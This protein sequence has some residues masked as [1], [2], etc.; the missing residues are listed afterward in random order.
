[1][2][3]HEL[4]KTLVKVDP[5]LPYLTNVLLGGK[6]A[7]KHCACREK[8]Q[9]ENNI[10]AFLDSKLKHCQSIVDVTTNALMLNPVIQ[11]AINTGD[12]KLNGN[13]ATVQKSHRQVETDNVTTD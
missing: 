13:L 7:Q 9:K 4:Y 3:S 5:N 1:M 10:N 8:L 6:C 2:N 11:L 12:D